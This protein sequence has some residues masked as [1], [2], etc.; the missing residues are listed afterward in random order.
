MDERCSMAYESVLYHGKTV[1]TEERKKQLAANSP[2]IKELVI[3]LNEA[4]QAVQ[5]KIDL[6]N[7]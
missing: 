4:K 7:K 3:K 6:L 2:E 1:L 5:D